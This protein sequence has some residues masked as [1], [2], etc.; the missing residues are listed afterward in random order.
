VLILFDHG[1]PKGLI[2]A[3]AGHTVHTAQAKGWDTLSNG[4]LL[5]VAEDAGFEVLVTT[6]RRIRYQQ[7]LAA[8][9][10]ALVVLVRC[11]KCFANAELVRSSGNL[12]SQ[13]PEE[14]DGCDDERQHAEDTAERRHD[15][16]RRDGSINQHCIRERRP[17]V[18]RGFDLAN[19]ALKAGRQAHGIGHADARQVAVPSRLVPIPLQP[20]DVH[21]LHDRV[22]QVLVLCVADHAHD[23][24]CHIEGRDVPPE[25]RRV[26]EKVASEALVDD[27]DLRRSPGVAVV[28][29]AAQDDRRAERREIIGCDTLKPTESDS[30]VRNV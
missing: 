10:I 8:R 25:R 23:F 26:S 29:L 17:D 18:K 22:A 14:P 7:N 27:G 24:V 5:K 4:A 12:E 11:S 6:D 3:L 2:R 15:L 9:P 21:G 30:S 1:T 19:Q 13:Q 20:R 28:E 16:F